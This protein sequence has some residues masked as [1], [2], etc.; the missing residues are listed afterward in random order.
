MAETTIG[1]RFQHYIPAD[2]LSTQSEVNLILYPQEEFLT[3][4]HQYKIVY[5]AHSLANF[6]Q[7]QGYFKYCKLS[8]VLTT[9][10]AFSALDSS[11]RIYYQLS[12]K[13]IGF[14]LILYTQEQLL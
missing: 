7:S 3:N 10:V 13:L 2:E 14:N 12:Q 5:S 4:T 1:S 11:R 9:T 6:Q 8:K